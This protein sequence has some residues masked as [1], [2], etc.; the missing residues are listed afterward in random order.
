MA[1]KDEDISEIIKPDQGFISHVFNFDNKSKNELSNIIQYSILA[2]FPIVILNKTI[3][4]FI[5][6]ADETKGSIE[7]LIE[8][9]LQ[10][11]LIF[12]GMF[13]IHRIITYIPTYSESKYDNLSVVNNI[14]SFLIIIL[15]LQTKLGEKMNIIID[16][17]LSFIDNTPNEKKPSETNSSYSLPILNTQNPII[18]NSQV[19]EKSPVQNQF[20]EPEFNIMAANDALGGAFGS[21]F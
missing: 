2:I 19:Q 17:I 5:P 14:I 11:G 18:S 13:F 12:V 8:I 3:Q 7:V 16:R 21:S 9:I 15:S 1:D 10:L 20:E 6:E 4:R